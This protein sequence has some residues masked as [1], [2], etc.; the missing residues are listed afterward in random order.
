MAPIQYSGED[1]DRT[2]VLQRLEEL[3]R[4][5]FV[6]RGEFESTA[7]KV[8]RASIEGDILFTPKEY[9]PSVAIPRI[10]QYLRDND[11]NRD[12]NWGVSFPLI[13]G[14]IAEATQQMTTGGLGYSNPQLRAALEDAHVMVR[15]HLTAEKRAREMTQWTDD[16]LRGQTT[17]HRLLT[18]PEVFPLPDPDRAKSRHRPVKPMPRPDDISPLWSVS[19]KI[20]DPTEEIP[21]LAEVDN[22]VESEEKFFKAVQKSVILR[23]KFYQSPLKVG[24]FVVENRAYEIYMKL[25]AEETRSKTPPPYSH[26]SSNPKYPKGQSFYHRRGWQRAALQQCLNLFTSYENRAVNTPW[27]RPVLP[28]EPSTPLPN[29]TVFVPRVVNPNHV[30]EKEK[31]PFSWLHWSTQYSQ[32]VDFLADCQRRQYTSDSWDNFSASALPANFRG[33]R[34]YRGLSVHDQHWLKIGQHLENLEGFLHTAWAVAPRPLLR[35]IIRDVD[36]GRHENTGGPHMNNS[37]YLPAENNDDLQDRKRYWRRDIRRRLGIDNQEDNTE[38]DN[39]KLIDEFEI[40]W[41]RYLC[42]PSRTLEMCDPAKLPSHNLAIVFDAKLQSFFENLELSGSP[43]CTELSLWTENRI[44]IEDVMRTYKPTPFLEVLAYINGCA[45]SELKFSGD[46]D[47][48]PEHP[49]SCYQFS[50]E[51]AEFLC[52]ELQQLGRCM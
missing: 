18:Y 5:G 16:I 11:A 44:D 45:E 28:Y 8:A 52:V 20:H 29:D 13:Q 49:N 43:D 21:V 39:Y 15:A 2:R 27:R 25:G 26:N 14:Y 10:L 34:I 40:A 38:D 6:G 51:E 42:E 24:K 19:L 48:N 47:P 17:Q 4:S 36:A 41:L 23:E 30:D 12:V 35:A 22:Y 46:T 1:I 32:I 50:V 31:D 3:Y 9:D 7:A 33:P 37:L